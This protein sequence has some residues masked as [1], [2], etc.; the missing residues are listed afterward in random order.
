[1]SKINNDSLRSPFFPNS[2]PSTNARKISNSTT[3]ERNDSE[4]VKE[5]DDISK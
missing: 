3:L 4:R 2:S 5:L 1:M